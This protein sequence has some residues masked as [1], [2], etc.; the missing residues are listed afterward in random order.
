MWFR[1]AHHVNKT[2]FLRAA[3]TRAVFSLMTGL[4]LDNV[5]IH[6]D[7]CLVICT[8]ILLYA[9]CC[10]RCIQNSSIFCSLHDGCIIHVIQIKQNKLILMYYDL[11]SH[12]SPALVLTNFIAISLIMH[13]PNLPLVLTPKYFTDSVG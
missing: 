5:L 12:K 11:H 2:L 10:I 4:M 13:F 8:V 6:L 7:K 9:M 3:T 1:I